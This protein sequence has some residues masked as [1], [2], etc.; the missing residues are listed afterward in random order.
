MP[1]PGGLSLADAERILAGIRERTN[2]LGAGFSGASFEPANVA[3]MS[4]LAQALGL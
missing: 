3:P 1:E 4:R 2:L